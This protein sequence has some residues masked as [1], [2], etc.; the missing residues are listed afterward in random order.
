MRALCY[1]VGMDTIVIVLATLLVVALAAAAL[2]GYALMRKPQ[3]AGAEQSLLLLQ[4]Q[5]QELTRMLDSRLAESQR[6]MNESVHHQFSESQRLIQD[7][8]SRMLS[9]LTQVTEGVTEVR[10]AGKQ[11]FAL[12]DQLKNLER[13]LTHQKQRGSLGE[14]SLKLVLDNILPPTGYELQY[15]FADGNAVDAVV[16]TK[17]GLVPIDAKFSLDNFNR[18]AAATDAKERE[19]LDRECQKDLKSRIDETAK[20]IRPKEG[21]LPFAFMYLPAEGL[22]YDLMTR[23]VGSAGANSRSMIEYAYK[24]KHVIIVSPTTFAAYLQSVLYGFRAFQI[25]ESAKEIGKRVEELSRHLN[26]YDTYFKKL[27]TT[28]GQTVGH[29]NAASKELGKIDKDVLRITGSSPG[30][31]VLSLEKPVTE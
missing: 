31:D 17:E 14:E 4:S 22:Y 15:R 8:H 1:S 12:A 19:L 21:T 29:Y 28:L 9:H 27:G 25:E 16:K 20:Y 24:D 30:V 26:A 5:V 2:F 7:T 23:P 18:L 13:V 6:Q 10:E 3:R 11:V